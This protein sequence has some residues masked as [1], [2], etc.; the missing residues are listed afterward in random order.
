MG[1]EARLN[2]KVGDRVRYIKEGTDEDKAMGLC[3]PIDTWG[4]VIQV[5]GALTEVQWDEG[6]EPAVSWVDDTNIALLVV[7]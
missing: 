7:K 2:V 4:T 1:K 3:P 6:A 5:R